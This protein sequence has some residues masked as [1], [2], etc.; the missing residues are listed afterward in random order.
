[1]DAVAEVNRLS[2]EALALCYRAAP[3]YYARLRR[4]SALVLSGE[5]FADLN[6]LLI[7]PEADAEEVLCEDFAVARERSVVGRM[8]PYP[9]V[10][11]V[12]K[13]K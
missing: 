13:L 2:G 6:Y 4:N 5:P 7:G 10:V 12:T 11:I 9:S 8:S 1:M 3:G